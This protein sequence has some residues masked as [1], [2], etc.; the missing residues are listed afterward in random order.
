M[1]AHRKKKRKKETER[2]TERE[3]ER[4]RSSRLNNIARAWRLFA[5]HIVCGEKSV[6]MLLS[7]E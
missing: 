7:Q 1:Q 4:A 3:R 5:C 6:D 2:L